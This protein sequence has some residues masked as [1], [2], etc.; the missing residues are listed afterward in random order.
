MSV[1]T[2]FRINPLVFVAY[3]RQMTRVGPAKAFSPPVGWLREPGLK[4]ES[5]KLLFSFSDMIGI[6]ET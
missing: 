2:H 1:C 6:L 4:I 5:F 3:H